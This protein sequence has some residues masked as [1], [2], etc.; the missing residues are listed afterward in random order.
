[1]KRPTLVSI[2][3]CLSKTII[4]YGN[5]IFLLQFQD[6]NS[7]WHCLPAYVT[8]FQQLTV[9]LRS[10]S[11]CNYYLNWPFGTL[12]GLPIKNLSKTLRPWKWKTVKFKYMRISNRRLMANLPNRY[13]SL[14]G[15]PV[16]HA[17]TWA[18]DIALYRFGRL[19]RLII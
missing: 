3:M 14:C 13:S 17:Q 2:I 18:S 15:R 1:M 8:C 5:G 7:R 12:S 10:F 16:T 6:E 11:C 4:I 19:S 9:L